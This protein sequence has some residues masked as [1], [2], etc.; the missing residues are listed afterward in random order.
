MAIAIAQ[1]DAQGPATRKKGRALAQRLLAEC[2]MGKRIV[3]S[4]KLMVH[5]LARLCRLFATYLSLARLSCEH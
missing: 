1:A 5:H 4:I 3:T 2:H